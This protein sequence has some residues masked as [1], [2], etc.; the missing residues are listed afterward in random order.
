M[1]PAL[2]QMTATPNLSF[3]VRKDVGM[4]MVNNWHYHAEIEL[5]FIRSSAGTWLIG[6]HIG[7][8][9]TGDV[10][11]T[12]SNLPHC[13]RH[14]AAHMENGETI[15]VK[16]MPEMLGEYFMNLPESKDI[17]TLFARA[18][19]GLRLEGTIREHAGRLIEQML[20]DTPGR[21]MV[22]LLL[23]LQ[24]IADSRDC[25]P[26][27][28][29]GFM[30][31][32]GPVTD[33]ERVKTIFEYT[34]RHYREKISLD[35][36]AGLLHMTRPS[37]CRFFK[38]R[39]RK[40]YVQFLM[41]VRIGHA[42]KLLVEDEKTVSEIGYECGYNNISHFNHQFKFITNKKPLEYKRDYLQKYR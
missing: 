25:V 29:T 3:T 38:N 4:Q 6:D 2:R 36:V 41:E 7:H 33:E 28:S 23:L 19:N 31:S 8:F 5:L 17:R 39:T 14:E 32:P 13:F 40:T 18:A 37:F 11:M 26:L 34:M 15:C 12:G 1:K 30:Q 9:K 24:D 10:V 16:F 20:E 35:T 21:R 27:S 42:C 22:S